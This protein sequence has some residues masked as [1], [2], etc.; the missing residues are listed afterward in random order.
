MKNY[1]EMSI[2]QLVENIKKQIEENK[3]E[4]RYF[5]MLK[6][7][8][9]ENTPKDLRKMEQWIE[10]HKNSI[11]RLRHDASDLTEMAWRYRK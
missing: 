11:S 8:P 10:E 5:E 7:F 2:N 3:N 6:L 1:R 9:K 4:I